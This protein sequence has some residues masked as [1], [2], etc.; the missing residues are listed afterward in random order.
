MKPPPS[1]PAQRLAV[2]IVGD[3]RRPEWSLF[4]STFDPADVLFHV[5]TLSDAER[6][7][8]AG[9]FPDVLLLLE[10]HPRQFSEQDWLSFMAHSPLTRAVAI[11]TDWC[12]SEP[13]T[14]SPLPGVIRISWLRWWNF[15]RALLHALRQGSGS[16]WNLPPTASE[17]ERLLVSLKYTPL[18]KTDSA[19]KHI[20][21]AAPTQDS[22]TWLRQAVLP[23]TSCVSW[24]HRAIGRNQPGT[25]PDLLI[26]DIGTDGCTIEDSLNVLR[27]NLWPDL[28]PAVPCILL[29]NFPRWQQVW[30]LLARGTTRVLSKPVFL[31]E[32]EWVLAELA[33]TRDVTCR[34]PG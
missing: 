17:E 24:V 16:P 34:S 20:A 5:P 30:P 28:S 18:V 10:D 4:L 8:I 3:D 7:V 1:R 29:M 11:Y 12:E 31:P 13:R 2:S 32:L 15:G 22:F 23:F 33:Q 21:I 14:G 26:I 6:L 27:A 19:L 9:L 25:P